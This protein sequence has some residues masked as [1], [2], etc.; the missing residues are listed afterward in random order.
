M[1][2]E[3]CSAQIPMLVVSLRPFQT[4][5][6]QEK[7]WWSSARVAR[8]GQCSL[9]CPKSTLAPVT[10]INRNVLKASALLAQFG[11]KGEAKPHGSP[12]P[13]AA[14]L[15]NAS[16]LGMQ[17][18]EPLEIDLSNMAADA[19]V[20]DLV[21]APLET[22]LLRQASEMGLNAIDGLDML[23]GQAALAFELFFGA[24]PPA[25]HDEELRELLTT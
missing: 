21:Y 19:T 5:P 9:P 15:V 3:I 2:Q 6:L 24:V 11:L 17:G 22:D 16:A 12:L 10:I 4:C 18:Q 25:E 13:D 20:Y 14:L 1:K 23:I 7:K 8:R